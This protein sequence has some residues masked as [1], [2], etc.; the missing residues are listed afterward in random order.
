VPEF[1]RQC[2]HTGDQQRLF[3][4]HIPRAGGRSV[5]KALEAAGWRTSF[6]IMG[7][8]VSHPNYFSIRAHYNQQNESPP[9]SFAICR[10]PMRRLESAFFLKSRANGPLDMFK[11]LQEMTAQKIYT[12]W[13][14]HLRPA[15]DL[16][17]DK[18]KVHKYEDGVSVCLKQ[19]E[20]AGLLPRGSKVPHIAKSKKKPLNWKAADHALIEKIM[21]I[22]AQDLYSFGYPLFPED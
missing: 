9:Q 20:H 5:I 22:Y 10:H 4:C 21:R 12:I 6:E 13:G 16:I 3:F 11:Q 17:L 7:N 2:P 8:D 19:L 14:G 18:T 1:S 15:H